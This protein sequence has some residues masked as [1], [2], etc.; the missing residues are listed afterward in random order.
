MGENVKN[1][2]L[3]WMDLEMTGL[4]PEC[5]RIIEVATL[6]TDSELNLI[7]EGPVFYVSQSESLLDAMDEWNTSH[8]TESGLVELVR[9][10]GV[11]EQEAEAATIAFLSEHIEAGKSPL[12]GNSIGQDRRFLVKYMPKLEAFLHYRN[13]DV[14][15]IKELAARWRPDVMAGINK[16]GTHRA[17]DDIKESIEELRYY[18]EHF[19]NIS[20]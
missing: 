5:E 3:V 12:C 11:S 17:M 19:F 7:A 8:H 15:T 18:R 10:Q 4:D 16:K 2:P 13:V 9:T 1:Q 14:S 6:I 20:D